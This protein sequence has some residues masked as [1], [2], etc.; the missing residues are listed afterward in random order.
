V[1]DAPTTKRP[2]DYFELY[3]TNGD[4]LAVGWFDRFDIERLA[5]DRGMLDDAGEVAGVFVS[6]LEGD[7]V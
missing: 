1:Y 3:N 6:L 2:A 4:L 5:V 7:S